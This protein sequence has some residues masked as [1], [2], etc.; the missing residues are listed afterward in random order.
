VVNDLTDRAEAVADFTRH[1]E[2]FVARWSRLRRRKPAEAAAL[3]DAALRDGLPGPDGAAGR[4]AVQEA[5]ALACARAVLARSGLFDAEG[6]AKANRQRIVRGEDPLRHYCRD[7]WRNLCA[8]SLDFDLWWYWVEHLDPTAEAVDPLL[9]Y[10]LEGRRAGLSPVPPPAPPRPAVVPE[11]PPRRVCLFAGYDRDGLVDPYVVDYLRE[12][13]RFADVYYLAD[14]VLAPGEL[15]KVAAVTKGAWSIPHAAYDF[16]S[17]S[18]LARDLVG[19]DL[20]DS[21]DEL[22]L[23]NDSC[24]LVRPL[25][26]VFAR[27][28]ARACDWWSLQATSMEHHE[29]YVTDDSP[30]P[31]AEAKESFIGPRRW[32]DVDYLH[33]SSYFLAFRAPV[34]QDPGFRWRID[35]VSGQRDKHMVVHKYEVGLSR[36]LMDSGFDF[37][38]WVDGL[39]AFH[40]LYS[41]HVFELLGKGFPLVKRN[42]LAENPR[43]V[44]G[45]E[46]WPERVR[47]L[48]PDAPVELMAANIARVS[49]ADRHATAYDVVVSRAG[50]P[51]PGSRPLSAYKVRTLDRETASHGHWWGFPVSAGGHRM[52]PGVRSVFEAV[53]DDPSIHKV[54]LTRS[55]ALELP[56][57][58]VTHLPI[59]SPDGQRALVRCGR[60]FVDDEPDV[61]LPVALAPRHHD[62][63][64]VGMGLPFLPHSSVT[65]TESSWAKVRAL[66]VS[67]Q[68][69][70]L[71]RAAG[72]ADLALDRMWLTGLPRHDFLLRDAAALP[73]DVVAEEERLRARLDGRPLLAWW[74]R[75]G[76]G[77]DPDVLA[78][79]RDWC[80]EN[81][82]VIGVR[83]ARPDTRTSL[84]RAFSTLGADWVDLSDRALVHASVAHRVASAV[85]TDG[86]PV[87]FDAVLLGRQVVHLVPDRT[88]QDERVAVAQW[89]HELQPDL[90]V[91]T[92]PAD[93]VGA[94]DCVTAPG[95]ASVARGAVATLGSD[96]LDGFSGWRVAQRARS[97]VLGS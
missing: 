37:D 75:G 85:V 69:E 95:T 8:P 90:V 24:F 91:R 22:L 44:V 3:V 93:L 23:A 66:V 18:I 74:F 43:H 31:L 58:N 39:Y 62:F 96:L 54:V 86:H 35:T 97:L 50:T 34:H 30:I 88:D 89:P 72:E 19:W 32:T 51:V 4:A 82:V 2:P 5:D 83:D 7:G 27:M 57:E 46:D 73:H 76:W 26:E 78:P 48:V 13:G 65:R 49:P 59:T 56:G 81:D 60:I 38:T 15:D 33:L 28:D 80:R 94:L 20:V 79:V 45:L 14:G 92:T 47:E 6:Y 16:G 61:V 40:P 55:R 10:A 21:Y 29:S 11:E 71:V 84:A 67:S 53:R 41:R 63:V 52:D 1:W 36:Y 64:H 12:I 70:A 77:S 17:F 87:A 25:D 68:A 42:F 9:H